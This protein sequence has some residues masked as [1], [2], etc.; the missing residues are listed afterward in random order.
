MT[1]TSGLPRTNHRQVLGLRIQLDKAN[2]DLASAIVENKALRQNMAAG[3]SSRVEGG[4]S[5]QG[6]I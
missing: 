2:F 3:E 1:A 5:R 4:E 6:A